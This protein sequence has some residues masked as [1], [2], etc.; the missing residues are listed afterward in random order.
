MLF[1]LEFH[2]LFNLVVLYLAWDGGGVCTLCSP[3][4][5]QLLGESA[6]MLQ[7]FL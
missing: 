7:S 4:T 2:I 1:L 5:K 6:D 3:R